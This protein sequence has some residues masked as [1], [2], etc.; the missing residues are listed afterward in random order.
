M[1]WTLVIE[2]HDLAIS[3]R[4]FH[5]HMTI[6]VFNEVSIPNSVDVLCSSSTHASLKRMTFHKHHVSKHHMQAHR[7]RMNIPFAIASEKK[8]KSPSFNQDFSW[9]MYS[10]A[11]D[12]VRDS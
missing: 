7:Q 2:D 3:C 11:V 5:I 10:V 4:V 12:D 8:Q 1:S 6:I 9:T